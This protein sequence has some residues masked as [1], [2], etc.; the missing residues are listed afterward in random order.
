MVQRVMGAA[1]MAA[2]VLGGGACTVQAGAQLPQIAQ[3]A[4]PAPVQIDEVAFQ[5]WLDDLRTEARA[6]GIGPATVDAA[7]SGIQPIPKVIEYDRRQPEFSQTYWTYLDRAVNAQRIQKGQEMLRRHTALLGEIERQYGV[8]PRFLVAF[9]GLETNFGANFGG[10]PVITALATLAFDERRSAFFR[11]ELLDALAIVDA[12]HIPADRMVGSWAGAMGHLQF[13]PSTFRRHAVDRTGD[14]R[15]DIWGSLP[16]V[17]ASAANYLSAE[18]WKGDQTWGREVRLP[19]GFDLDNAAMTV[20]K[21]LADWAALGVRRADGG[22]LTVVEGMEASVVLP[23]GVRGPAFLVYEN[24]R[25]TMKWN[26]SILYAVAVGHLADRLAG[27]PPITAKAPP[28]A[29]PLSR[30]EVEEIQA[31]LNALGHD[32]GQPDGMAGPQT[33][34]ALRAF[35][36]SVGMPADGHADPLVLTRLRSTATERGVVPVPR[37]GN[38]VT[39]ARD[40]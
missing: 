33:R 4:V 28:D 21:S 26:R 20:R 37:D 2:M 14:G 35:Q 8:Q 30:G 38:G 13:M 3:Q 19:A 25:V 15:A 31:L 17:F 6:K 11:A 16:D 10:F 1:L 39:P 32:V 29:R 7:L 34:A 27:L 23:A 18:G 24:F 12:G 40:G 22:P 9:W 36:K 5:A